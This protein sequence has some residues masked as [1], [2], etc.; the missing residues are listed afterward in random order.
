MIRGPD[1]RKLRELR[2]LREAYAGR[3]VHSSLEEWVKQVNVIQ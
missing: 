2:G 3:A 1:A